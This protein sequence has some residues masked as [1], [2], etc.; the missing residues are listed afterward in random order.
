VP[1]HAERTLSLQPL[2]PPQTD[3]PVTISGIDL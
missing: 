2:D 1:E 3:H